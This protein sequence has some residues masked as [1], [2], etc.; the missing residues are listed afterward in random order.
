MSKLSQ[1]EYPTN[2]LEE[3][4]FRDSKPRG[5]E[6]EGS[7]IIKYWIKYNRRL[8]TVELSEE[9]RSKNV[10][11]M[12]NVSTLVY[13]DGQHIPAPYDTLCV[14]F[15]NNITPFKNDPD[16]SSIVEAPPIDELFLDIEDP[17][18]SDPTAGG[19]PEYNNDGGW[20]NQLV[21][22]EYYYNQYDLSNDVITDKM[23]SMGVTPYENPNYQAAI[24]TYGFG[25][26]SP[27]IGIR[28]TYIAAHDNYVG[29]IFWLTHPDY[30]VITQGGECYTNNDYILPGHPDLQGKVQHINY[31][32]TPDVTDACDLEYISALGITYMS[33][34]T[35]CASI[36]VSHANDGGGM[37]GICPNCNLSIWDLYAGLDWQAQGVGNTSPGEAQTERLFQ[38][39]TTALEQG[40]RA[41]NGSYGS[42]VGGYNQDVQDAFQFAWNNDLIMVFAAGNNG[43]DH[44]G[45][46]NSGNPWFS[47]YCDYD[48]VICVTTQDSQYNW[49]SSCTG[50]PGPCDYI[51]V[52]TPLGSVG[53]CPRYAS[54]SG[55]G[56]LMYDQDPIFCFNEQHDINGD[57]IEESEIFLHEDGSITSIP[58]T[59]YWNGSLP[60]GID[61]NLNN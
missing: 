59:E 17:Y 31:E 38:H 30:C 54:I 29:D 13:I 53:G 3:N 15:T 22:G 40:V 14:V 37:V 16:I 47:N 21:V 9:K 25:S 45:G 26:S 1:S 7:D 41:V 51:D 46:N 6:P 56:Q 57:S 36:M 33:H 27:L 19:A 20:G 2:I 34:G 12:G 8:S 23:A 10:T 39:I 4:P 55:I 49:D 35:S 60:Q 58:D 42:S 32:C 11:S 43:W 50:Y 52:A 44:N 5:G 24:D 48:Y 28:D 18:Y 61:D